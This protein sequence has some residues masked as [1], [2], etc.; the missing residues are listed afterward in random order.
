MLGGFCFTIFG[1]FGYLANLLGLWSD[2][3]SDTRIIHKHASIVKEA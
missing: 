2:N 1:N 3:I